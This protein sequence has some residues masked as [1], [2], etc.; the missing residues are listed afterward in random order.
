FIS[1]F[2]SDAKLESKRVEAVIDKLKF[3]E[4]GMEI[5]SQGWMEVYPTKMEEKEIM[6]FV[7]PV[8]ILDLRSEEKMTKPPKRFS[9]ASIISELEKRNLGT[10]ATRSNIIDTLYNRD[11]VKDKSIRATKLGISLIDTLE[12]HSPIIIDE[13]LTREIEKDMDIIR[14]SKKELNK[15]QKTTIDL[16]SKVLTDISTD[17]KKKEVQIGK[18]LLDAREAHFEEEKENNKLGM[19]CPECKEGDIGLKFSP[20]FKSYFIACSAY[21]NCKKTYSLPGKS[22]VKKAEKICEECKFPMVIVLRKGKRPWQLCFNKE[23][24]GKRPID[25]DGNVVDKKKAS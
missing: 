5:K 10:K 3:S 9:P 21:P 8:D 6:D 22:F 12:K 25:I 17:F 11:Y 4:R 14:S 13:K 20:R 23:C 16:A 2:C 7:G 19:K 15:K 18:E 1:C 24:P